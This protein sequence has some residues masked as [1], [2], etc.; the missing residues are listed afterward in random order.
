MKRNLHGWVGRKCACQ[1]REVAWV[2]EICNFLTLLY[3]QNRGGD[4]K[5]TPPYCFTGSTRQNTSQAAIFSKLV[6]G[7]NLHTHGGASWQP[8]IWCNV[9]W[10]GTW[11]T[12]KWLR[13]REINGYQVQAHTKS[14]RR[15][16][17][18]SKF[19]GSVIS[20]TKIARNGREPL[21]A[22]VFCF[23]MSMQS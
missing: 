23:R 10:G 14:L 7:V 3:W 13:S 17:H 6:W 9:V 1:R 4:F 5:P 11:V 12:V 8:N 16:E 18:Q 20:S 21:S 19:S 22:K 2:F 15:R